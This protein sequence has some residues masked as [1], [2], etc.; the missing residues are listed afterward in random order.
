MKLVLYAGKKK[1]RL[2]YNSNF[3]AA[4]GLTRPVVLPSQALS[5]IVSWI[6]WI[7][8]EDK[9]YNYGSNK[10]L[11][12]CLGQLLIELVWP[13][14]TKEVEELTPN[15]TVEITSQNWPCFDFCVVISESAENNC[16]EVGWY[17]SSYQSGNACLANCFD[18]VMWRTGRFVQESWSDYIRQ[19]SYEFR[20]SSE[21]VSLCAEIRSN[22]ESSQARL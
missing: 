12:D 8:S 19:L 21:V 14:Y 16:W 3:I 9:M 13:Q 18:I 20:A 11:S 5:L 17:S 15:N 4:S 7:S 6:S 22:R 2:Y 1:S 10:L